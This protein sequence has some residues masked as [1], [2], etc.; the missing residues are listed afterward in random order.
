MVIRFLAAHYLCTA[1]ALCLFPTPLLIPFIQTFQQNK[2]KAMYIEESGERN[3]EDED[4]SFFVWSWN[5]I[6]LFSS[7]P[8]NTR[9]MQKPNRHFR[10]ICAHYLD[11]LIWFILLY[12]PST[13]IIQYS[14]QEI[15]FSQN[16]VTIHVAKQVRI[17]NFKS[18]WNNFLHKCYIKK[19][20]KFLTLTIPYKMIK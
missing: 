8:L 5:A 4:K 16:P 2:L 19:F 17:C 11:A 9:I 10:T 13:I 20:F 12:N 18:F 6:R 14:Q 1:H 7:S 15:S 3:E